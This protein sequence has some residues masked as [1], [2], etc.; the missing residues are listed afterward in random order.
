LTAAFAG[1]DLASDAFTVAGLKEDR[2]TT[3]SLGVDLRDA[4]NTNLQLIYDTQ[5]GAVT[6]ASTISAKFSLR[7]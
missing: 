1:A 5:L 7:F 6:T 4:G 3:V 2:F